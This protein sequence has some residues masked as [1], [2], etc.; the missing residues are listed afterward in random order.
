VISIDGTKIRANASHAARTGPTRSWSPPSLR[1]LR[2]PTPGEDGPL[3]ADRGDELPEHLRNEEG[4][5]AAFKAA[6]ER[7]AM[8]AGRGP[9]ALITQSATIEIRI[10]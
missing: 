1:R 5:R 4:R 10:R 6:K 3:S 7:L 8:K 9:E 2:R